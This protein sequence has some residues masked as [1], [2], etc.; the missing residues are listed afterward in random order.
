MKKFEKK[1]DGKE[2][3]MREMK[4]GEIEERDVG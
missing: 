3:Q 2:G 4:N 1:D